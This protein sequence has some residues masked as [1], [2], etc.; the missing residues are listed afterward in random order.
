MKIILYKK[1]INGK[2]KHYLQPWAGDDWGGKNVRAGGVP[3]KTQK[4]DLK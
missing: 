4:P 2:D 1:E 3:P